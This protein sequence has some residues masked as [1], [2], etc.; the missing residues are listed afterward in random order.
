MLREN[1]NIPGAKRHWKGVY[2]VAEGPCLHQQATT[3]SLKLTMSHNSTP[4]FMTVTGT[5]LMPGIESPQWEKH[6]FDDV[7]TDVQVDTTTTIT[8]ITYYDDCFD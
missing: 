7:A 3:S 5:L 4:I 8:T 6:S 1:L 2:V